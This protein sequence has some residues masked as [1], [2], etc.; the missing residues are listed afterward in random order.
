MQIIA[1]GK[2]L[3]QRQK[4]NLFRVV[5]YLIPE[6]MLRESNSGHLRCKQALCPFAIALRILGFGN[7]VGI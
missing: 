2:E 1:N 3:Q 4:R 5:F 7:Q 6:K